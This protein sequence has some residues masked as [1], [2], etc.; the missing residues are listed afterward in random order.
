MYFWPSLFI[1]IAA[2]TAVVGFN[3]DD[4]AMSSIIKV[5]S[6]VFALLAFIAFAGFYYTK[7]TVQNSKSAEENES[8]LLEKDTN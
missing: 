1:V 2:A 4:A 7:S 5:T 8:G 6:L 3:I